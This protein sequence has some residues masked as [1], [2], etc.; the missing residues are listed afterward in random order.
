MR[1]QHDFI[2]LSS[3]VLFHRQYRCILFMLQW[4]NVF[5]LL[6]SCQDYLLSAFLFCLKRDILNS[7]VFYES[8][9]SEYCGLIFIPGVNVRWD[10]II[11]IYI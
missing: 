9:L 5:H 3:R 4:M 11:N 6:N 2:D 8:Q 7:D 10:V 1:I